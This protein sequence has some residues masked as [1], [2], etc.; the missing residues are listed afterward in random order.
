MMFL[1]GGIKINLDIQ[2]F[3]NFFQFY[4]KYLIVPA[5]SVPSER[6][7][8]KAGKIIVAKRSRHPR[9]RANE[10]IFLNINKNLFKPS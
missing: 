4:K 9:R 1:N 7:F 8:S 6:V 3:S 5:T 2:I 10:L